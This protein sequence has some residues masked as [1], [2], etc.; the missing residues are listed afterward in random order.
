MYY[1]YLRMLQC[2]ITPKYN[3]SAVLQ[4]ALRPVSMGTLPSHI[5]AIQ[6]RGKLQGMARKTRR[7]VI[8][9]ERFMLRCVNASY[10]QSP[11]MNHVDPDSREWL[12]F[13]SFPVALRRVD[14]LRGLSSDTD[15]LVGQLVAFSPSKS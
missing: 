4:F 1:S 15:I 6:S 9:G 8:S 7:M 3:T 11:T 13:S 5:A 12:W 10:L 14:Q 2:R